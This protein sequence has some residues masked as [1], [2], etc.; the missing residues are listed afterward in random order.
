LISQKDFSKRI[1]LKNN[2]YY[3]KTMVESDN[4]SSEDIT[5]M[6]LCSQC[7]QEII[8]EDDDDSDNSLGDF[9]TCSE[10]DIDVKN[11]MTTK[12]KPVIILDSNREI[13][14]DPDDS[15]YTPEGDDSDDSDGSDG[16]DDSDE[17]TELMK[18]MKQ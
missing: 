18:P 5:E 1:L 6:D 14:T 11:I 2:I 16:S 9:V 10:D 8:S 13:Q 7:G 17:C 15:D 3:I 12:R 4:E